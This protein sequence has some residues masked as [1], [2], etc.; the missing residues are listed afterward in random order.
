MRGRPGFDPHVPIGDFTESNLTSD[1]KI[2]TPE[3]MLPGAW[4]D[5]VIT[6]TGWP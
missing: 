3:A 4:R 1:S 5:R 2:G 6:G